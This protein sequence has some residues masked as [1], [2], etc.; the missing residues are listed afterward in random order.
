MKGEKLLAVLVAAL[1]TANSAGLY[2]GALGLEL[3]ETVEEVVEVAPAVEEAEKPEAVVLENNAVLEETTVAEINGTQYDTLQAA[4]SAAKTGE[5]VKLVNDIAIGLADMYDEDT[6]GGVHY[7]RYAR[8][9]KTIPVNVTL[10]LNGHNISLKDDAA[11]TTETVCYRIF[12]LNY[13]STLNV[14]GEGNININAADNVSGFVFVTNNTGGAVTL[15]LNIDG[16][17]Y[18]NPCVVKNY[19]NN[20]INVLGG[21][22]GISQRA[23]TGTANN[24]PQAMFNSQSAGNKSIQI[25][26]GTL[27]GADPKSMD[28]GNLL[29]PGYAANAVDGKYTVAKKTSGVASVTVDGEELFF[30][31]LQTA[32]D[33]VPVQ[34][35]ENTANYTIKLCQD[36]AVAL[37]EENV[38]GNTRYYFAVINNKNITLDFDGHSITWDEARNNTASNVYFAIYNNAN[39]TVTGNGSII[40]ADAGNTYAFWLRSEEAAKNYQPSK[41]T[42]ESCN[43]ESDC[44]I[45][46]ND[47]NG[48]RGGEVVI[49]G[50]KFEYTNESGSGWSYKQLINVNGNTMIDNKRITIKG[51]SYVNCD[52][53]Y[54]QDN[55]GTVVN[56][57]ANSL[58]V[59]SNTYS[60]EKKTVS[61]KTVFTVIPNAD[62][63]AAV[64]TTYTS[65]MNPH[66]C[67]DMWGT[68]SGKKITYG[69]TS[70]ADA[71]ANAAAGDT[72]T[73][74]KDTGS[75]GIV[76]EKALTI[77]LNS[78][79]L[80]LGEQA[81][82]STGTETN[83]FQ[84]KATT[85]GGDNSFTIKNGTIKA[86]VG[87][88]NLKT[89]IQNYRSLTLDGV[90]LDGTSLSTA[91]NPKPYTLS[92]NNGDIT[93]K[94][95][96]ITAHANGYAFDVCDF[97]SYDG[98]K[99][100]VT[101]NTTINGKVQI[102]NYNGGVMNS[103]LVSGATGENVYTQDG[104]Y[105]YN[106]SA[107]TFEKQA[108]ERSIDVYASA[109][110][111]E[112]EDTVTI[113][114][115]VDGEKIGGANYTLK[116]N[117]AYFSL[118]DAQASTIF[119]RAEPITNTTAGT[120]E[121]M[122]YLPT[123]SGAVTENPITLVT[124]TFKAIAQTTD[125]TA[126]FEI[127]D[128]SAPS[129]GEAILPTPVPDTTTN[130]PAQVQITLKDMG[131]YNILVDGTAITDEQKTA[132]AASVVYTGN[133]HTFALEA[134][135]TGGASVA[136]VT[137]LGEDTVTE[138][139]AEGVY[140]ITYTITPETGYRELVETFTL[141]VTKPEF[142][143]EVVADDYVLGNADLGIKA[144][145]LV[146]VLANTTLG[147][148]YDGF[149][150]VDVTDRYSTYYPTYDKIYGYVTDAIDAATDDTYKAKVTY[151]NDTVNKTIDQT[152][153][154][155][156]LNLDSGLD[157][158]DI[159]VAYGAYN[160]EPTY[161]NDLYQA[162]ILKADV[163]CNK[164]IDNAD[165]ASVV[166]A[167]RSARTGNN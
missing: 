7:Y 6:S 43:I 141:T 94:D 65:S 125:V 25:K 99:V 61:G 142:D 60:V 130:S 58:M 46:V 24:Y 107:K 160:G 76:I 47:N 5:T 16:T 149:V 56:G 157:V 31:T 159:I 95:S 132:K 144:K 126:S 28:D 37:P 71:V 51:G 114:V 101:G 122:L 18:G 148:K 147:F 131:D 88:L 70:L 153:D 33:A 151:S 143:V 81:V 113:T 127:I 27:I 10:D 167:V 8:L 63:V 110:S 62:V 39:V 53:R 97:A 22:Y 23:S 112:A 73:L 155:H 34:S 135:P 44:A 91:D 59:D 158:R 140:T 161:F 66:C 106:A 123:A 121:E 156:D 35:A 105:L 20:T 134:L 36:I 164:K 52:P 21:T 128:P 75:E 45:Y 13:G 1:L 89:L 102:S 137:K 138:I 163:N 67:M 87:T 165:P 103:K 29:A 117:P 4:L 17:V 146:L 42:I 145:K 119:T 83:G 100:T 136:Y 79:T 84:L 152:L 85:D 15:N 12:Y 3:P 108:A 74:T 69:Y 80:T 11:N 111:V 166:D 129:M 104:D 55:W 72:I 64:E 68:L 90:T 14:I 49:N 41:L 116:Y 78:K 19:G 93:I 92:N 124:Y 150:M 26:G 118:E 98:A 82:G 2:A 139:K 54:F 40:G 86:A 50:G 96:T 115:K 9:S 57:A 77:D 30:D 109:A 38:T 162:N 48:N 32:I 154:Q 120:I 133:A